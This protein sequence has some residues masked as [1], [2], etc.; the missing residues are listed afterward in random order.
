MRGTNEKD[1]RV[2]IL[3]I[4]SVIV[5]TLLALYFSECEKRIEELKKAQIQS[6]K[7]SIVNNTFESEVVK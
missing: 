7:Y 4:I 2:L 3:L 5:F 1:N 6:E